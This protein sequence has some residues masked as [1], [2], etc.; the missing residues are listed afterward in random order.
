MSS[1]SESFCP[2]SFIFTGA[3]SKS[4]SE[5]LSAKTQFITCFGKVAGDIFFIFRSLPEMRLCSFELFLAELWI[6]LQKASLLLKNPYIW[7]PFL[8]Q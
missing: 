5:N 6:Q 8:K 4:L 2:D 3:P 7:R 1:E